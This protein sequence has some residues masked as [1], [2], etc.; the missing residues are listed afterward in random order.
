MIFPSVVRMAIVLVNVDKSQSRKLHIM[1]LHVGYLDR[2]KNKTDINL[3][4][5]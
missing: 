3:G 1:T 2:Y 5:T 4:E